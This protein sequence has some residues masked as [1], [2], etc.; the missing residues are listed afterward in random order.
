VIDTS[1]DCWETIP[2]TR[3]GERRH[4]AEQQYWQWRSQ[5][6]AMFGS[7]AS[8]MR[9]EL[10]TDAAVVLQRWF[11]S[12]LNSSSWDLTDDF[13]CYLEDYDNRENDSDCNLVDEVLD[14][15]PPWRLV[16]MEFRNT[17]NDIGELAY[18]DIHEDV[19]R[20]VHDSLRVDASRPSVCVIASIAAQIIFESWDRRRLGAVPRTPDSIGAIT[21]MLS[22][23][24]QRAV[25]TLSTS[26][27]KT[28]HNHIIASLQEYEANR[29]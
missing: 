7:S 1:T 27:M 18:K 29:C 6:K 19:V 8:V 24:V 12:C 15:V 14:F 5:S 26:A 22:E 17:P 23:D 21:E 28:L 25:T 20:R 13:D 4:A 3:P 9:E 2:V 11:R 10:R 16:M